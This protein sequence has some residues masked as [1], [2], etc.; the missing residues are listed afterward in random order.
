MSCQPHRTH[1]PPPPVP[2][3]FP[4]E[5]SSA[6]DLFDVRQRQDAAELAGVAPCPVCHT[7]LVARMGRHGP[8]FHCRCYEGKSPRYHV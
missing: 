6:P 7:P 5:D 3:S 4:G 2:S 1:C 8:Y